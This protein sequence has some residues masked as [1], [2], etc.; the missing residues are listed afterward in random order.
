LNQIA[1]ESFRINGA[2]PTLFAAIVNAAIRAFN[3]QKILGMRTRRRARTAVSILDQCQ[4]KHGE[5]R[6]GDTAIT[7]SLGHAKLPVA[8]LKSF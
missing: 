5:K 2:R 7:R 8:D 4:E 3:F 6:P 1:S